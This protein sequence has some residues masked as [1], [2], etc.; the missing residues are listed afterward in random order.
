M[1]SNESS[2]PSDACHGSSGS[3]VGSG[4]IE[5]TRRQKIKPKRGQKSMTKELEVSAA[6][7]KVGDTSRLAV[8]PLFAFSVPMGRPPP[9]FA[10]L[11]RFP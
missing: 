11:E 4:G 6:E 1:L 8:A 3:V 7:I 5:D 2:L 10:N 9:S